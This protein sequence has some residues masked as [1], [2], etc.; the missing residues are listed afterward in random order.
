M[1]V[2]A[3][4]NSK[5]GTGKTTTALL[6][7]QTFANKARAESL[8]VGISIVDA[9]PNQPIVRW[10]GGSANPTY[11]M[12]GEVSE[13]L[14]TW[15]PPANEARLK[16]IGRVTEQTI[17]D[18]I[19]RESER[20]EIVIIDLEGTRSVM[21][22][23]ALAMS[24]LIIIPMRPSEMDAF[25][26]GRLREYIRREERLRNRAFHYRFVLTGTNQQIPTRLEK[27]VQREIEAMGGNLLMNTR[28]HQRVAYMS[29]FADGLPV[30]EL[31]PKEVN[32]IAKA[33]ENA[34]EFAREV[35]ELIS[36]DDDKEM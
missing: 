15:G 14:V 3:F 20:S 7:A 1:A 18:V 33:L 27:T 32:G 9:D 21:V 34:T 36:P 23:Y 2:I 31:D 35:S 6:L 12:V 17:Q 8:S 11:Q 22:S 29:M 13:Q 24:H 26:A 19:Q 30:S 4:A 5:G 10:G 28:V 16:V 25:E